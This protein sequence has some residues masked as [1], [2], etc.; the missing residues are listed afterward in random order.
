MGV[1]L[2][3]ALEIENWCIEN[4]GEKQIW[5]RKL[6]N[7]KAE[8]K[9][10]KRLGRALGLLKQKMKQY[11]GQKLEEVENEEDRR[12]LEIIRRLDE[13]Y[14]PKKFKN[15]AL[16]Q[17]KQQRDEAKS[18]NNQAKELEQQVSEQLKKR[19]QVHDEQ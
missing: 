18:K 3:N 8:N 11:E 17:A 16:Q 19:G 14:N 12:I 9:E 15:K 1:L 13:E 7:S 10:E 6:P 5:E 2:K 4:Y